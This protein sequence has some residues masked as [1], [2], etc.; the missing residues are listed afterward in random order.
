LGSIHYHRQTNDA[1]TWDFWCAI[2]AVFKTLAGNSVSSSVR[3]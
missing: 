3:K 1:Q 2:L